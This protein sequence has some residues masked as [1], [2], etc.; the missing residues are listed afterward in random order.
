MNVLELIITTE[1]KIII[2]SQNLKKKG[3]YFTLCL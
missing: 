2:M 1:A 3:L